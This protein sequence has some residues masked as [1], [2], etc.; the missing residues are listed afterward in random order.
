[1][2]NTNVKLFEN[3]HIHQVVDVLYGL[4]GFENKI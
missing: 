1:M 4:C 3:N 2:E